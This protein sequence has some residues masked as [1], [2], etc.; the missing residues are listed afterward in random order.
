MSDAVQQSV[1]YLQVLL[2]SDASDLG[3]TPEIFN[4]LK[5]SNV[6]RFEILTHI[7][8]TLGLECNTQKPK[9]LTPAG[10]VAKSKVNANTDFMPTEKYN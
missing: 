1:F 2:E 4:Q 10:L 3:V 6:A 8:S 7:L 9:P 5:K